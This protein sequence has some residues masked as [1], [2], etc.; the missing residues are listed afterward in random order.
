VPAEISCVVEG[1]GDVEA[2]P[3]LVRR[4][5]NAL[6]PAIEVRIQS[7][8]RTPKSKLIKPGELERAV[9]FAARKLSGR[10]AVLVLMD[11]DDDCP[12]QLG[13]AILA[14]AQSVR[15]DLL[16][17]VVIAKREFESWFIASVA[18]IAGTNGFPAQVETPREPESIS[19]AKEWLTQ[20]MA[21]SRAY[22]PTLDQPTLTNIFSFDMALRTDSFSKCYR[23]VSRILLALSAVRVE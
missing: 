9:D 20:Q 19:G 18:S 13:P 11:S 2:V 12:G 16:V 15:N 14:R 5:A 8:I 6:Q 23:E 4:I 22:S 1:H 21:G 7:P 10:G 3:I 17:G